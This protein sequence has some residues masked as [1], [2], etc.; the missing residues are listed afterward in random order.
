M[1]YVFTFATYLFGFITLPFQT[2]VLG[3]SLF[4]SVS[5][6]LATSSVFGVLFEFGFLLSATSKV[7]ESQHDRH[8]LNLIFSAV[9]YAKL[10]L[11]SVSAVAMGGL[12]VLIPA[13]SGDPLLF[14]LFF[15]STATLSLIPDFLYRG[16]ERMTPIAVRA[17]VAQGVSVILLFALVHGPADYYLVPLTSLVPNMLALVA[18]QSHIWQSFGIRLIVVPWRV[19]VQSLRES[20]PYFLSRIAGR[21]AGSANVLAIGLIYP[22]GAID[23]GIYAGVDRL[24]SAANRLSSPVAD[25]LYPYMLRTSDYSRLWRV[26]R[27]VTLSV[28]CACVVGWFL[29]DFIAEWVLGPEYA[30]GAHLI[31]ILLVLVAVTPATYLLGF[32]ALAPAGA[33]NAANGSALA[34]SMLHLGALVVLVRTGHLDAES[35]SYVLVISQTVVLFYRIVALRIRGVRLF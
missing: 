29:A 26:L 8:A 5:L 17:V 12:I 3:P 6:A 9:T 30:A 10:T 35:A 13:F 33:A 32:P 4:G 15:A 25:S 2:R 16:L 23:V 11:I 7:S 21:V 1:L 28:A 31:R 22:V 27:L 14:W 18:V 24:I 20:L 19:V 34:G